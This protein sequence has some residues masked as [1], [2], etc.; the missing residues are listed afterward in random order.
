[1]IDDRVQLPQLFKRHALKRL[2]LHESRDPRFPK[3]GLR[4]GI[5]AILCS[6]REG[7]SGA[8][9]SDLLESQPVPPQSR[10]PQL[11][12]RQSV[13]QAGQFAHLILERGQSLLEG[14]GAMEIGLIKGT[15]H[16]LSP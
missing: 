3:I 5:L 7:L 2:P 10:A 4:S 1:M 14:N 16:I 12:V 11:S 9:S 15:H 8:V 13:P 6:E